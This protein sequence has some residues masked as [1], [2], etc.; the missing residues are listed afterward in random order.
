[1]GEARQPGGKIVHVFAIEGDWD[2]TVLKSNIFEMTWPP[3]ARSV[4]SYPEFNRAAWFD[5]GEVRLKI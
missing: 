5:L 3:R 4:R 2:P 1:L